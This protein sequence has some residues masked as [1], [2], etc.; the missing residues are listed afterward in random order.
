MA[1]IEK[2]HRKKE[3]EK[4]APEKM[5]P[6]KMAPEKM[7]PEKMAPE[8]MAP[9]KMT[10]AEKMTTKRIAQDTYY[11]RI[12]FAFEIYDFEYFF[13]LRNICSED[14]NKHSMLLQKQYE[15]DC[16]LKIIYSK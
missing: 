3:Q 10:G 1:V 2:R 11:S 7:A 8:K 5:A 12:H 16:I 9:E 14:I 6:E 15:I 13:L 4:V